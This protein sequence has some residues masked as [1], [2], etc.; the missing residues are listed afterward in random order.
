[1]DKELLTRI[2][3]GDE[4]AFAAFVKHH[5][6]NIY[7][8]CL[9]YVKSTE[10][11]EELTQD[12]FLQLWKVRETLP[13]LDNPEDYIYILSRNHIFRSFRKKVQE[14]VE[15]P[16]DLQQPAPERTDLQ[17]E[18]KEAYALLMRGIELLP[19]KRRRVFVMSRIEGLSHAEIAERTGLH[20]VTVAQYI[21][22]ALDFLKKYLQDHN[23]E[24]IG[25]ILL[26]LS[27]W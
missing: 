5:L 16:G 25:I 10:K 4:P 13:S 20:K 21:M 24:P 19:E 14:M 27:F 3:R 7:A 9:A 26:I 1:M 2:A 12:I 8:H 11:A 23:G 18:Y 15:L 22:L 17:A 6:R